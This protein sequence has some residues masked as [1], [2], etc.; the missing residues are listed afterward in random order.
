[1][2]K[3]K[4]II[5]LS[6]QRIFIIELSSF[7]ICMLTRAN[8]NDWYIDNSMNSYRVVVC[9]QLLLFQN[10]VGIFFGIESLPSLEDTIIFH[11]KDLGYLSNLPAVQVGFLINSAWYCCSIKDTPDTSVGFMHGVRNLQENMLS[12]LKHYVTLGPTKRGYT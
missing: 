7:S 9:L 3:L 5:F 8:T 10:G 2:K 6:G 11:Y 4:K 12:S 1:M